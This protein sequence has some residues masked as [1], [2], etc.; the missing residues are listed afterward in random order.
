M[1]NEAN[2]DDASLLRDELTRR[3]HEAE[4]INMSRTDVEPHAVGKG[5]RL[6]LRLAE[7]G[8]RGTG[9]SRL[10]RYAHEQARTSQPAADGAGALAGTEASVKMKG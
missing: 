5:S 4:A 2:M 10:I 3:Q 7:R 9:G 6:S 1:S 8:A